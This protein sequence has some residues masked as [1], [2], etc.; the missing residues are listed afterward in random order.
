ML[1]TS[2]EYLQNVINE[3]KYWFLRVDWCKLDMLSEFGEG[4][5]RDSLLHSIQ[6][7]DANRS[8]PFALS[9]LKNINNNNDSWEMHFSK[10]DNG[11]LYL[12]LYLNNNTYDLR[13]DNNAISFESQIKRLITEYFSD[14]NFA[15]YVRD[16]AV[17]SLVRL[18]ISKDKY[19]DDRYIVK[20]DISDYD[21]Y[22]IME[23]VH[24]FA[25][26]GDELDKL[27][28]E[29]QIYKY[30]YEH[31]DGHGFY[32]S[33]FLDSVTL[34]DY[35]IIYRNMSNFKCYWKI[36]YK[37]LSKY[38][39]EILYTLNTDSHLK[40]A[41]NIYANENEVLTTGAIRS[42]CSSEY[43]ET[44]IKYD[45]M[46]GSRTLPDFISY[47]NYV[48]DL[49]D[50]LTIAKVG[51]VIKDDTVLNSYNEYKTINLIDE[52]PTFENSVD[53]MLSHN[54]VDNIKAEIMQLKLRLDKVHSQLATDKSCSPDMLLYKQSIYMQNYYDVLIERAKELSIDVEDL[55]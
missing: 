50:K 53:L 10:K 33:H 4:Y 1:Q 31:S 43:I 44:E 3:K 46:L 19:N 40:I 25:H 47:W 51:F 52:Q 38:D 42:Y 26:I 18:S 9:Y 20:L 49:L 28:I 27:Y 5:I 39:L 22:N 7:T 16:K 41:A 2:L 14:W 8:V 45:V 29:Y 32:V 55:I 12:Y 21:I 17:Q 23:V 24:C 48:T 34:I 13:N 36:D 30:N 6:H 35:Y 54:P 15:F 37:Y 11:E